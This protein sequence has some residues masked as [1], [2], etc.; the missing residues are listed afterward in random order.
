MLR[1]DHIA[2]GCTD[3]AAGTRWVEDILGVPL[4]TG[5]KHMQFGT[6]NT[7][8]G[9]AD[10]L[11]LEVICKD[12]NAA[13][14]GRPTWFG[15]DQFNGQP[16]LS[17]WICA[18]DHLND[19]PSF[20]GEVNNLTRDDLTWQITVPKD[21]SLPFDG[22]FPTMI[23]WGDGVAHPSSKFPASGVRL[24]EWNVIHP[25]AAHLRASVPINDPRVMFIEG[26]TIG[27]KATFET[28][29]GT[30]TLT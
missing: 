28:P 7:L 25:Q 22:G 30:K 27:F 17:N 29:T 20:A 9:L 14:T 6:H 3:L 18:A 16:R 2:V 11:Y 26:E 24:V 5:G 13:A 23:A 8:L 19:V 12:P 4:V 15:L 21:G 1:L 10:G